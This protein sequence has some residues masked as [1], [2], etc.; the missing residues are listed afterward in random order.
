MTHHHLTRRDFQATLLATSAAAALPA[1]ARVAS[2]TP[3][4][5]ITAPLSPTRTA[6]SDNTR[7]LELAEADRKLPAAAIPCDIFDAA[8]L[9]LMSSELT[10]LHS[11]GFR[12]IGLHNPICAIDDPRNLALFHAAA[13]L[14]LPVVYRASLVH[15]HDH[16]D[17]RGLHRVREQFPNLT[18]VRV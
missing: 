17:A 5:F 13:S 10:R 1:Y 8:D 18:L 7:T 6:W 3:E 9:T 2:F 4:D 14:G 16:P 11:R 15:N 12:G